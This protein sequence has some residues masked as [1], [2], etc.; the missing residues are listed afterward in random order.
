M[1]QKWSKNER[2]LFKA[3]LTLKNEKEAANFLRDLLTLK[4]I[5]EFSKRLQIAEMLFTNKKTYKEIAK[6]VGT[7]TTTVTRVAQ[8][9]FRGE[10]GYKT[11]LKRLNLH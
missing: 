6:K 7:S 9:L 8:W 2:K 11:V 4:E 5:E 10:D 1:E 3:F